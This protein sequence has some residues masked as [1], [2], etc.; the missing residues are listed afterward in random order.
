MRERFGRNPI[1]TAQN[2]ATFVRTRASF[3]AQTTLYG[4]LKTRMGTSFQRYFEDDVFAASIRAA[5]VKVFVACA[6][7]MAVFAAATAA[8]DGALGDEDAA[9]LAAFCYDDA[10]ERGIEDRDRGEIPAEAAARFTLRL[11][12]ANWQEVHR[13]ELAFTDSPVALIRYAPVIDEYK[14]LDREIVRNSIRFRWLNVRE[15]LRKRIE[16]E[17]VLADWRD[18]RPR[19]DPA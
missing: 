13:G 7:D 8:R 3:I 1:R 11:S 18:R 5:S 14:D 10:L 16:P 12:T 19:I 4:Y 9:A 2:L 17:A 15:T 6:A